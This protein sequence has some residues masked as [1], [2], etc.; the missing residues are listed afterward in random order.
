M[1]D[2]MGVVVFG[3][4][5]TITGVD[6]MKCTGTMAVHRLCSYSRAEGSESKRDDGSFPTV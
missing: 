6:N 5:R 3:D 2:N 1:T 4:V